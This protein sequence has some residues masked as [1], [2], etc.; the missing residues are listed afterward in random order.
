MSDEEK[1]EKTSNLD[2]STDSHTEVSQGVHDPDAGLSAEERAKIVC[3][4]SVL[5]LVPIARGAQHTGLC[6]VN[7]RQKDYQNHT[8]ADFTRTFVRSANCYGNSI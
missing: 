6:L 3:L 2:H 5:C 8:D 1:M 7:G 4:P